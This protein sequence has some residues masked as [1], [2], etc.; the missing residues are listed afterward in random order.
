MSISY[1][2]KEPR[3]YSLGLRIGIKKRIYVI[4]CYTISHKPFLLMSSSILD[5]EY[6][7]IVQFTGT[8][9]CIYSDLWWMVAVE[10][11]IV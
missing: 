8:V 9:E 2:V 3:T 6:E 11:L 7:E 4:I 5:E 1:I 10:T